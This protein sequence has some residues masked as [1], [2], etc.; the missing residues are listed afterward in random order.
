MQFYSQDG[1]DRF[2][3]EKIFKHKKHGYFLDIGAFDGVCFSNTFFM[4][5]EMGWE[6]ICIEPNP[7]VYK[8]LTMNRSCTSLNCCV[9]DKPATVKF[10]SISGYGVMLSGIL[11]FFD[12][13]HIERIDQTL[14]RHG[15][16]KEIIEVPA[17]PLQHIIEQHGIQSI[18]YCNI[19]VEGGEL[20]ILKSIDFS[21]VDIKVFTVEN[22]DG[23]KDVRDFLYK[24]GY[25]LIAKIG[26]DEV[27]EKHS[28]RYL[29]ICKQRLKPIKDY[30]S[31]IKQ[32]LKRK[33]LNV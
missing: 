26:A 16:E 15:G 14:K 28:K 18:D 24:F 32:Q 21:E 19:D 33:K 23:T 17:L 11:E 10:V 9:S 13:K 29:M 20:Q 27:Y 1:Q 8:Q 2:L 30:V 25:S 4:E 5:K 12:E 7:K 22:N 31:N 3:V 6:G